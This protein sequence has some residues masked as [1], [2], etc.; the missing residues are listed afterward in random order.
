MGDVL[1]GKMQD[2]VGHDILDPLELWNAY[3]KTEIKVAE[4]ELYDYQADLNNIFDE[5]TEKYG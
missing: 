4:E 1:I 3:H 2:K 5:I